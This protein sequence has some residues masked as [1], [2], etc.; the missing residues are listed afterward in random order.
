MK[1][2]FN[3]TMS[4]NDM[5][6]AQGFKNAMEKIKAQENLKATLEQRN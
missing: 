1:A 4:E 2:K 6:R 5:A 3:K